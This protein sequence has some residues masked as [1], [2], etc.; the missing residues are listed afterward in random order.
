MK[1]IDLSKEIK[2]NK[3]DPWYMRI[4]IKHKPHKKSHLLLKYYLKLNKALLGD[5]EGWADDKI[6][7]MG[8]HAAT[9]IDAPWHYNATTAGKP[10]KTIDQIPLEY[11]ISDAV[12]FEASDKPDF[13]FFTLEDA[14]KQ[15][16]KNKLEIKQNTIVLFR[17]GR[18]KY[19]GTKE[20]PDKGIGISAE[21]TEW[22][23][24]KGV[25]IMGIDQWGFDLPLKY[26][27]QKAKELKDPNFFWQSHRVGAKKEYYH[28]EQLVNLQ[29]LPL[30]GF[31]ISVLPLKIMGASAAPAR[32]VAIIED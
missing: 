13:Q 19:V 30:Q 27:A 5:F 14:K 8:V 2:Y 32:V 29:D 12:I 7:G 17:T 11:C 6:T 20:Y 22:L 3:Q 4:K 21:L 25:K 9:H 18:D 28:I 1:I 10:A 16:E 31:K 23:I 26:M 24:D 15:I